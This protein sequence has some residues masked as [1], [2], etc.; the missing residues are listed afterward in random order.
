MRKVVPKTERYFCDKCGEEMKQSSIDAAGH[1]QFVGRDW[2]G[3]AVGGITKE[4]ELCGSCSTKLSE[5]FKG[6]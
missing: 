5:F 6:Q 1:V 2:S 4:F 3:A